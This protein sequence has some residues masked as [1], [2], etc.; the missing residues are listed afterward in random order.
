MHWI[1][2]STW[3]LEFWIEYD[4]WT[5]ECSYQ[6]CL[7]HGPHNPVT[8]VTPTMKVWRYTCFLFSILLLKSIES[9]ED[10]ATKWLHRRPLDDCD[11]FE[12]ELTFRL[13]NTFQKPECITKMMIALERK[14]K[15]FNN[16]GL[17]VTVRNLIEDKCQ[18][19][20]I[21]LWATDKSGKKKMKFELDPSKCIKELSKNVGTFPLNIV[22]DKK[23]LLD[24]TNAIFKT[25]QMQSCLKQAKLDD[26]ELTPRRNGMEIQ[27]DRSRERTL[28][29]MYFL[30]TNPS[31]PVVKRW[32]VV[33][34][35][36]EMQF[37][38]NKT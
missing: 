30:K 6:H 26:F 17:K 31:E 15:T 8:V 10:C 9:T 36:G 22:D 33:P 1:E 19:T 3:D 11:I 27:L 14:G 23:I 34:R 37:W 38:K 4:S 2:C 35:A 25:P 32:I 5:R 13:E 12:E 7:P 20:S 16:P 18:R 29:L 24:I 28:L 21:T